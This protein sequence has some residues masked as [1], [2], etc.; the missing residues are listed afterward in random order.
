[1][2]N[3]YDDYSNYVIKNNVIE[4][5]NYYFQNANTGLTCLE[6]FYNKS[7]KLFKEVSLVDN[8]KIYVKGF[9]NFFY[10]FYSLKIIIILIY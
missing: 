1:M 6:S 9:I 4:S 2:I 5:N 10:Y 3:N 7:K 8:D